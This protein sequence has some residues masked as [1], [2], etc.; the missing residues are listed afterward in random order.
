MKSLQ[1]GLSHLYVCENTLD[2]WKSWK[3]IVRNIMII[4]STVT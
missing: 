4:G 2:G 1:T 3:I